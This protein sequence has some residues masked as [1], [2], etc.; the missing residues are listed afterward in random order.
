MSSLFA[1]FFIYNLSVFVHINKLITRININFTLVT[2]WVFIYRKTFYKLNKNRLI[3][4][5][6][7]K[8]IGPKLRGSDNINK[9]TKK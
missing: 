7:I 5:P 9:I 3:K 1:W 6:N 2:Y 8:Q 4:C